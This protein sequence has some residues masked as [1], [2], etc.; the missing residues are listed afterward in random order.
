[1]IIPALLDALGDPA[2]HRR[3]LRVYG[4][5]LR[6]LDLGGQYRPVKGKVLAAKTRLNRANA[7]RSVR[8]LAA[9]GYLERGDLEDRIRTYR[10]RF[11]RSVPPMTQNQP[12]AA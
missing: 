11:S 7:V 5:L 2:L 6:E 8:R 10:L 3:D 12:T 9:L 1:M 4:V